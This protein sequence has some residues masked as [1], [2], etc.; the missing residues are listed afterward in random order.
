MTANKHSGRNGTPL[1]AM[2]SRVEWGNRQLLSG[3][4]A[5]SI[6]LTQTDS[7]LTQPSPLMKYH[8]IPETALD[9]SS[10]P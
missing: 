5:A 3:Q 9:N 2:S 8:D 10:L 6:R 7:T 4:L 1:P